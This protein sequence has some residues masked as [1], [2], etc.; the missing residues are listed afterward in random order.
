MTGKVEAVLDL[1]QVLLEKVGDKLPENVKKRLEDFVNNQAAN[2]LIPLEVSRS[3]ETP[4][5][6]FL[7][8]KFDPF[9]VEKFEAKLPELSV[10]VV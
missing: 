9:S 10:N 2:S 6:T 3:A 4:E 7:S 5:W 1:K 8:K